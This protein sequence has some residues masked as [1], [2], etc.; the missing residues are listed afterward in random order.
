MEKE[1]ECAVSPELIADAIRIYE[2]WYAR[3]G[4]DDYAVKELVSEILACLTS[5]LQRKDT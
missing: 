1:K 3:G 2:R 5:Y 4:Q